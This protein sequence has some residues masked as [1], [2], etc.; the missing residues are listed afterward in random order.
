MPE[1]KK[2]ISPEFRELINTMHRR[3][4]LNEVIVGHTGLKDAGVGSYIPKNKSIAMIA[5]NPAAGD[6][7]LAHETVH[8]SRFSA[9]KPKTELFRDKMQKYVNLQPWYRRAFG[10]PEGD[11]VLPKHWTEGKMDSTVWSEKPR[12]FGGRDRITRLADKTRDRRVDEVISS[13]PDY[14]AWSG[15]TNKGDEL[16]RNPAIEA[17]AYYFTRRDGLAR[18]LEERA[19]EYGMYLLD[20]GIPMKV[21]EPV[22]RRLEG[23]AAPQY[24]Y[25]GGSAEVGRLREQYSRYKPGKIESSDTLWRWR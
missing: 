10:N 15:L 25:S 14:Q 19:K 21:V 24:R 6:A 20:Y 5:E 1:R 2:A 4:L 23:I 12:F 9:V 3:G 13:I 17:D 22:V 16:N 11:I 7:T 8:A 18:P